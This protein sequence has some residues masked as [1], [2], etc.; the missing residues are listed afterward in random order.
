MNLKIQNRHL[1]V[2]QDLRRL[3]ERQSRKIG[4][5]L[6]TFASH[7]LNLHVALEKLP[8]GKQFH[9]ALVLTMPQRAIRVEE[10]ENDPA[11]SVLRSFEELLRR[12]KRFKS[13]LNR[14]KFW[15]RQPEISTSDS[16]AQEV[17]ELEGAI[18]QNLEK[19]E[20]YIRRELYHHA[21]VENLP[22]SA[23]EPQAVL[24]E[25]FLEVSSGEVTRPEDVPLEQW[26]FQVAR[27]AL[28]QRI[29][30]LQA[31]QEQPHIEEISPRSSNWED[32]QLHFYQPDEV[33]RLEDLM[34]DDHSISP[35]KL[36]EQEEAYEQLQRAVANLPGS[37]RES[38][39]LFALEGFNSDEIAMVTG[40]SPSEVLDDV[41]RARTE[42][43][44]HT[45][46]R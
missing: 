15:Q 9:A 22:I 16:S 33:L 8:R 39:V 41:E 1:R 11:T 37:V 25:V 20:N 27:T 42:L 40:K 4:K 18:E 19:I 13:Q 28:Q 36:L 29:E 31:S 5:L 14:E 45:S 32:E 44:D 46:A 43:R 10:V 7:D 30:G 23:L 12:I 34:S 2:T 17:R 6:P 21:T 24:D 26:M 35:E 3:I 38:F